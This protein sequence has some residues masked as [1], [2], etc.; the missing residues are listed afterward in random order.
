[1]SSRASSSD[2][3]LISDE[4]ASSSEAGARSC[5][6]GGARWSGAILKPHTSGAVVSVGRVL[7]AC[8]VETEA[9]EGGSGL[10][11]TRTHES[12]HMSFA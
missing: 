9:R 12:R 10:R 7:C 3:R 8:A 11:L 6:G 5:V 1:M 4:L 2:L